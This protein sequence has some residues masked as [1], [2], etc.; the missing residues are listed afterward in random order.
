VTCS[1]HAFGAMLNDNGSSILPIGK[2]P[3]PLKP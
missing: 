2:V 1:L 3:F